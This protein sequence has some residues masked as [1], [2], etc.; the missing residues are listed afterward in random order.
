[1]NSVPIEHIHADLQDKFSD[2]IGE[3]RREPADTGTPFI[4][5]NGVWIRDVCLYLRDD[6]KYLMNNLN[7]L[8]CVDFRDFKGQ[9]YQGQLGVVYHMSSLQQEGDSWKTI[10]RCALRAYVPIADPRIPSVARVWRTADWHE[11]EGYDMY[12]ITFEGH[13]DLR[14][15]LLPEDW[16]GY[17]LRKDYKVPDYY[18][19]MK[20][21]Y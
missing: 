12:G 6:S 14:R 9:E 20:I 10:H 7:L 19:G 13:P 18:N 15:I 8:S 17:P 5:V 4:I 2:M 3:L 16:E 11:R 1:M 21:P